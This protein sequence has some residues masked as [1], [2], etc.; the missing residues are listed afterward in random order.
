MIFLSLFACADPSGV[1]ALQ[2]PDLNIDLDACQQEVT[3]NFSGAT[4]VDD[5]GTSDTGSGLTSVE[6]S[7]STG[8]LVV[9]AVEVKGENAV[10]V[11]GNESYP[12]TGSGSDWEFS[13]TSQNTDTRT[14]T[15]GDYTFTDTTTAS[16]V[17]TYS[18]SFDGD[19][20]SGTVSAEIDQAAVYSESDEWSF[21][22]DSQ[23]PAS[24][25]LEVNVGGNTHPARNSK[26]SADC[27]GTCS[28]S[29]T[30]TCP[31]QGDVTGTRTGFD[32]EE[33]SDAAIGT[34]QN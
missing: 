20:V 24:I 1:W 19:T 18:L 8:S 12:G 32:V 31:V 3:H 6:T 7:E 34:G 13:W 22:T 29:V 23:I 21:D 16:S 33:A 17:A 26:D 4:V 27:D 28:L 10:M 30:A 15:G 2:V 14:D 5:T 9:V 11:V 25:Y